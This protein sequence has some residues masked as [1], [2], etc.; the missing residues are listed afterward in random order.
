MMQFGSLPE[1]M[2]VE[3]LKHAAG[4]DGEHETCI[5]A[6]AQMLDRARNAVGPAPEV[7]AV[8]LDRAPR[9]RISVDHGEPAGHR[10]AVRFGIEA[11]LLA[12]QAVHRRHRLDVVHDGVR[13]GLLVE[14]AIAPVLADVI[15]LA[16]GGEIVVLDHRP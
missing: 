6:E 14:A 8:D 7:G 1:P 2:I 16:L 10:A 12:R 3:A 15:G 9:R 11:Q 13:L 5:G 4:F